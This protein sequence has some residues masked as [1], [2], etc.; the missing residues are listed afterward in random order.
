MKQKVS[1]AVSEKR[2]L[3][4]AAGESGK[5]LNGDGG[6]TLAGKGSRISRHREGLPETYGYGVLAGSAGIS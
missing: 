5:G 1:S 6:R 3:D 4:S 2:G